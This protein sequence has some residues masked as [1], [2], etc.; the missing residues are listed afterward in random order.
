MSLA[1]R[2]TH[3]KAQG[4]PDVREPMSSG[5][6]CDQ[7]V[8]APPA[9]REVGGGRNGPKGLGGA[10][11]A[12]GRRSGSEARGVD[13]VGGGRRRPARRRS[14]IV[15]GPAHV[16]RKSWT[17]TSTCALTSHDRDQDRD[18]DGITIGNR[19]SRSTADGAGYAPEFGEP[20]GLKGRSRVEWRRR[21]PWGNSGLGSPFARSDPGSW[22]LESG[23][24]RRVWVGWRS[25][26]RRL[27]T[28]HDLERV[29]RVPAGERR[30]QSDR[31]TRG[32]ARGVQETAACAGRVEAL[33][34]AA[35]RAASR[36][37]PR[38][39]GCFEAHDGAPKA[40]RS[41][42]HSEVSRPRSGTPLQRF[43]TPR[44]T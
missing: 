17:P 4:S 21:S 32:R 22:A 30:L 13:M 27:R 28:G 5:Q 41:T 34:G 10:Q 43:R 37:E 44:S 38:Q 42:V 31:V 36:V 40:R 20:R 39:L 1:V 6:G 7:R 19:D 35:S 9:G 2:A 25:A 14:S 15:S 29:G 26:F 11:A 3:S 24:P 33:V 8:G 12:K 23:A 18:P 16:P